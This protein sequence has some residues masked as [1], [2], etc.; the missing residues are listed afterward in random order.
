VGE[1]AR[2]DAECTGDRCV[3]R[4]RGE[5]DISNAGEVADEIEQ[6]ISADCAQV[7]VDLAAT[8]YLDSS[9]ISLLIRLAERLRATRQRMQL[10]VP[11]DSPIRGIVELTALPQVMTVTTQ[12]PDLTG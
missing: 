2:I 5:V 10:V 3:V 11:E 8:A 6:S 9:G 4:V 12:L 1:L 7:V